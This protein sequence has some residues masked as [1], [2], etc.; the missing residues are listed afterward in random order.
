MVDAL[1]RR[2]RKTVNGQTANSWLYS[3]LLDV[4]SESDGL[5]NTSRIVTVPTAG[6]NRVIQRNGSVL[7]VLVPDDVATEIV[8]DAN[9]G[10]VV[11]IRKVLEWDAPESWNSVGSSTLGIT[12][13]IV[14]PDTR[15]YR[16]GARDYDPV[17]GR[18]MSPEPD[19]QGEN[20]YEYSHND[21]V[22]LMDRDGRQSVPRG[23]TATVPLDQRFVPAGPPSPAPGSPPDAPEPWELGPQSP[24]PGEP[25]P[26]PRPGDAEP[27]KLPQVPKPPGYPPPLPWFDEP[28]PS[29][30]PPLNPWP[31]P[32]P[33]GG[34]PAPAPFPRIPMPAPP[35]WPGHKGPGDPCWGWGP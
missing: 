14:D 23:G 12:G 24:K 20:R 15:L 4:V 5:G 32:T 33:P 17:T 19:Y 1:G 6:F 21:P 22:N 10:S 29:T 30:F 18:W 9:T 8:V 3:S 16:F 28:K 25:T 13:G 34:P 26:P 31:W 7:R 35:P 27:P 11:S 2:M